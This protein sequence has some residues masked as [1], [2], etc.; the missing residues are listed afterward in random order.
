MAEGKRSA[1]LAAYT[2]AGVAAAGVIIQH[3]AALHLLHQPD[4]MANSLHSA[5]KAHA[6]TQLSTSSS[7]PNGRL[8]A[9]GY[10]GQTSINRS[11][12]LGRCWQATLAC[13]HLE[14]GQLREAVQ[15]AS[16]MPH[17]DRY[18]WSINHQ[19]Q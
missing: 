17:G 7:T 4:L 14:A 10:L 3:A 11:A 15:A 8:H 1:A 12:S 18:G 6:P 19:V 5:M 13:F 2:E 9:E 16:D